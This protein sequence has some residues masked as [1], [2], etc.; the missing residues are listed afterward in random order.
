MAASFGWD[1]GLAAPSV[2]IWKDVRIEVY[3]SAVIRHITHQMIDGAESDEG[4]W[5]LQIFVHMETG[6]VK[7]GFDGVISCKLR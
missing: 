5:I 2:G 1:W 4:F 7:A 3:D 6:L